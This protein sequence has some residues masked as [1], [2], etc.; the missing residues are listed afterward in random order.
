MVVY[1][2]MR[3][4]TRNPSYCQDDQWEVGTAAGDASLV[5]GRV[6]LG[7][8]DANERWPR[9]HCLGGGTKDRLCCENCT[10]ST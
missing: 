3:K 6:S 10:A 5:A 9:D 2:V 7:S 4:R 8:E 1:Y